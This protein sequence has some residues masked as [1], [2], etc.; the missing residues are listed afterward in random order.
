[1][2]TARDVILRNK[3]CNMSQ[4]IINQLYKMTI[5]AHARSKK[6]TEIWTQ[7]NHST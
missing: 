3:A 4:I 1:M 7:Y 6:E 2:Q 5:Q